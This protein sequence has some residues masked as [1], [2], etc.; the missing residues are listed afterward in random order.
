M[1][2]GF[3]ED[4]GSDVRIQFGSDPDVRPYL[5]ELAKDQCPGSADS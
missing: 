2:L 4:F 1:T 3:A 5:A